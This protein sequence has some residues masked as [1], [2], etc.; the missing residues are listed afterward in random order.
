M[1]QDNHAISNVKNT[2]KT[3]PKTGFRRV[4][5]SKVS[6]GF[7]P[8]KLNCHNSQRGIM[9]PADIWLKEYIR[10]IL[11]FLNKSREYFGRILF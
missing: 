5:I 7:F 1:T 4:S 6:A 8:E 3:T 9:N 11:S 10:R 2:M